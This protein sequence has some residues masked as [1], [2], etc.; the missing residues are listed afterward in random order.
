M[1]NAKDYYK[2]LGVEEKD[3]V[4]EIKKIYRRLA[5]KYHPDKNAGDKA[6]EEKFKEISEAY[7]VLGDE[8]RRKEYDEMR[9]F[10]G[11][12]AHPFSG[13][14]GFNFNDFM[15]SYAASGARG[16]GGQRYS[17]FD[18]VFSDI[19][20]GGQQSSRSSHR[21][22]PQNKS[23]ES[24]EK[25]DLYVNLRIGQE[26]AE[27]GGKLTFTTPGGKKITVTIPEKTEVG[28]KMRLARQGNKCS[29]CGHPGDL[30]L[31]IAGIK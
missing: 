26:V 14:Q 11:G 7:Y 17:V 19:F 5:R 1:A 23:Q 6:A 8:K 15:G 22:A 13:A 16:S 4:A 21:Q 3:S 10:G 9:K 25:A 29:C 2:V 24:Q 30:I 18:D 27:K 20:G 31:T 28:K 12:G